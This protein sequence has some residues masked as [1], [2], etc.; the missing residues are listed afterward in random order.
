MTKS[1]TAVDYNIIELEKELSDRMFSMA[2]NDKKY[3]ITKDGELKKEF[4][5][6]KTFEDCVVLTESALNN[7][8]VAIAFKPRKEWPKAFRF[9]RL[10]K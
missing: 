6:A 4:D 10:F 8:E 1:I 2:E 9:Y 7:K 3:I 5:K